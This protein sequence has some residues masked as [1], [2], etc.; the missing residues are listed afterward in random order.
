MRLPITFHVIYKLLHA[1][2]KYAQYY[3]S[4]L[5]IGAETVL[6]KNITEEKYGTYIQTQQDAAI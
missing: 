3:S 6:C 1:S 4:A 2:C 5:I